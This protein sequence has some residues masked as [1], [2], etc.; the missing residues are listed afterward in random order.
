MSLAKLTTLVNENM[1]EETEVDLKDIDDNL[2]LIAHQ[3]DLP[4]DV[5]RNYGYDIDK[6]RVFTPAEIILVSTLIIALLKL[7]W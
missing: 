6:L 4:A 5:L 2:V 1:H 7:Q 3:E